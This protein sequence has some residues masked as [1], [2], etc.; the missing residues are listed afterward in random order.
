[1]SLDKQGSIVLPD[2]LRFDFSHNAAIEPA[3][4]KVRQSQIQALSGI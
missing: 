4:L 2:K 3:K 1:M